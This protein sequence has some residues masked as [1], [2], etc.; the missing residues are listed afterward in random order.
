[1][2]LVEYQEL[3]LLASALCILTDL[4]PSPSLCYSPQLLVIATLV[5]V[6][7]SNINYFKIRKEDFECTHHKEMKRV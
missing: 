6:S 5:S 1:M 3:C 7:T 4:F 2:A